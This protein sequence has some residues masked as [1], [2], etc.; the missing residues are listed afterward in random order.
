M[1]TTLS[2]KEDVFGRIVN[3]AKKY[4]EDGG[5][6][7]PY[8]RLFGKYRYDTNP[9]ILYPMQGDD[10]RKARREWKEEQEEARREHK[11]NPIKYYCD[12]IRGNVPDYEVSFE[13]EYRDRIELSETRHNA[14]LEYLE[15]EI[16]KHLTPP[17][18]MPILKR[19]VYEAEVW[20]HEEYEKKRAKAMQD[21]IKP[22]GMTK[23]Q[24]KKEKSKKR[25]LEREDAKQKELDRKYEIRHS[26]RYMFA[27]MIHDIGCEC[28]AEKM[29][30]GVFC[31][32][33]KLITRLR[34][35]TLDL[36][37]DGAEGRSSY[38]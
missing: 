6:R 37:K 19:R 28:E 25:N 20:T 33:C 8:I 7:Q 36:F 3:A 10:V 9:N 22:E 34:R 17:E 12:K 4:R 30:A 31:D 23:T 26:P 32:T 24:W 29:R 21:S 16:G 5:S 2:D 27:R 13:E 18:R 35:Y 14:A 11:Q 15:E 38:I 1:T